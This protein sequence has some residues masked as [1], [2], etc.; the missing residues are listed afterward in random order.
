MKGAIL[1]LVHW[2]R[3]AGTRDFCPALAALVGQIKKKKFHRTLLHFIRLHHPANWADSRAV[4]P[5]YLWVSL[6]FIKEK[7]IDR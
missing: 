5:V 1:W 7:V 6:G 2:A 3:H 4:T